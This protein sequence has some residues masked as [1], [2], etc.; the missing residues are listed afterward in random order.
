LETREAHVGISSRAVDLT[1]SGWPNEWINITWQRFIKSDWRY[2]YEYIISS[3][4]ELFMTETWVNSIN[5]WIMMNTIYFDLKP[6][7]QS[8]HGGDCI[9][10]S[11]H[12]GHRFSRPLE[13]LWKIRCTKGIEE[14]NTG[15]ASISLL[16][17]LF[18]CEINIK[19]NSTFFF[20]D[21]NIQIIC[22][23]WIFKEFGP[24]IIES[25]TESNESLKITRLRNPIVC[26]GLF[27][28]QTQAYIYI[29]LIASGIDKI[30]N[31]PKCLKEKHFQKFL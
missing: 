19:F 17:I 7:P 14:W 28:K 21:E 18:A 25:H 20:F 30:H 3:Q 6:S 16:P 1:I 13:N 27:L 29:H 2:L 26:S 22:L 11:T 24:I 15:L 31:C 10:S 8:I 9:F 12:P 23:K 5:K 4:S